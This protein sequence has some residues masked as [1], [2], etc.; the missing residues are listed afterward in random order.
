MEAEMLDY[1]VNTFLAV[2]EKG[3]YTRAAEYL[4]LT[5]PA[6]TQ[7]IH[8]LEEKY[9]TILFLTKDKKIRLTPE[10]EKLRAAMITLRDD[11]ALLQERMH[12]PE[13]SVKELAVGVTLTI[14]EFVI[15]K[16]MAAF[17]KA[18]KD[19]NIRI[20]ITNTRELLEKLKN[21]EIQIALVEGYFLPEEFESLIYRTERF[22]P[23]AAAGRPFFKDPK[24]LQ[25][26]FGERLIVRE[27]G[28][29]TREVLAKGLAARGFDLSDFTEQTEINSI[30]AIIQL[31]KENVGISFLY[32]TAARDEIVAGT[33][34]EIRLGDF[35]LYHDFSFIWNRGSIYRKEY[36]VICSEL[37]C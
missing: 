32:E 7:H 6:V 33:L 36:M 13:N 14:G 1:R 17:I 31:L 37:G 21:G 19:Y 29:G 2:C 24:K 26:L 28:S 34:R 5:Q 4:R 20:V 9:G 25:D 23:V 10:G 30:Y 8:F 18:H 27:K 3:S 15:A 12:R 35:S 16:P 22:I 11:E